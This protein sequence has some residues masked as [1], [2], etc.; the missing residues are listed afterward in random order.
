[1]GVCLLHGDGDRRYSENLDAIAW[2]DE[3][4]GK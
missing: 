3:N 2:Y 4:S 1:M